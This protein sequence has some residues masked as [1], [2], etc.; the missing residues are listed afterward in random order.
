V[1]NAGGWLWVEV[2]LAELQVVNE[3]G[4]EMASDR[5][6]DVFVAIL[7]DCRVK[8]DEQK[9][10]N[11]TQKRTAEDTETKSKQQQRL[12]N[13]NSAGGKIPNIISQGSAIASSCLSPRLLQLI[14]RRRRRFG[15]RPGT[16][17]RSHTSTK[18]HKISR[19]KEPQYS[20]HNVQYLQAR[21]SFH[22][23]CNRFCAVVADLVTPLHSTRQR[24]RSRRQHT[25]RGNT[26]QKNKEKQHYEI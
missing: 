24:R 16:L 22:G 8:R 2:K 20:S 13:A 12:Q 11:Q 10:A 14:L 23:C 7:C 15:F 6:R 3:A 1:R 26:H 5:S 18:K 17:Q 25:K 4:D 19:G 21:V 9:R